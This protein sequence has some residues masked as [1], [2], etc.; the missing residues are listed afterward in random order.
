MRE[1]ILGL[2]RAIRRH[3]E[4]LG[5]E[6]L[7][8][9]EHFAEGVYVRELHLPADMVAVGEIHRFDCVNIVFGDVEVATGG[10]EESARRLTGLSVF[11]SP[12]GAKR[13]VRTFSATIWITV[14]ANPDN[15]RDGTRI[16]DRLT[17]PDFEALEGSA[18]PRKLDQD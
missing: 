14:H 7:P 17:V 1:G 8:V 5:R 18:N 4:A 11:R 6:D 12:G 10:G 2:E 13:A 9:Y 3:P 16:A 15:E